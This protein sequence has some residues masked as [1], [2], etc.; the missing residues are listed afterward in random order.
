M[1]RADAGARGGRLPP[2]RES[3]G[4]A[5]GRSARSCPN[6][7]GDGAQRGSASFGGR[8]TVV[9]LVL[10]LAAFVLAALVWTLWD[11]LSAWRRPRL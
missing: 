1:R 11:V 2:G 3:P 9:V 8:G 5:D 6:L 10:V 7:G 4:H